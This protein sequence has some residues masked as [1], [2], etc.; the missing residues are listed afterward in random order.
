MFHFV[1]LSFPA[2]TFYAKSKLTSFP[3]LLSQSAIS[4]TFS[5]LCPV[6]VNINNAFLSHLWV[7]TV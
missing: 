4:P 7:A 6:I 3:Y 2:F 5:I 1:L